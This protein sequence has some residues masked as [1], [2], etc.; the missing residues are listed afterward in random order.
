MRVCV[1]ACTCVLCYGLLPWLI[2]QEHEWRWAKKGE[3]WNI[4]ATS[5]PAWLCPDSHT[6]SAS[7][8]SILDFQLASLLGDSGFLLHSQGVKWN[9]SNWALL[10]SYFQLGVCFVA[11][12]LDRIWNLQDSLFGSGFKLQRSSWNTTGTGAGERRELDWTHLSGSIN[13]FT[14]GWQDY[15]AGNTCGKWV[16]FWTP[17]LVTWSPSGQRTQRESNK[18]KNK[19]QR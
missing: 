11:V 18:D 12:V 1:C 7:F 4:K 2:Q 6:H 14:D 15:R 13:R 3:H 9:T 5:S 17:D 8:S 10:Y 19:G 16:K